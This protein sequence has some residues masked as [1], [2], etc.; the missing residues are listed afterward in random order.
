MDRWIEGGRKCGRVSFNSKAAVSQSD[1]LR[2]VVGGLLEGR[3]PA[4][5]VA[6]EGSV[7]VGIACVIVV[8]F[9]QL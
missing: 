7:L 6:R 9:T 1:P 8:E 5:V 4:A 3:E 2:L